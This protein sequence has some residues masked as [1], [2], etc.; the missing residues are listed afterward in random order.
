MSTVLVTGATGFIGSHVCHALVDDGWSVTAL[1]RRSSNP[2]RL[3]D[4]DV[5]WAVADVL[6]DAAVRDAI[7]GHTHVVHLAGV[8]LLD[9][10][11]E[12]VHRVNVVG[13]K[14]VLAACRSAEVERVVFTSTAGTR[15][16]NGGPATEDDVADPIGIY[17]RSKA[18]AE[19][20]VD[21]YAATVGDA[22]TVHP[23]SVFGPGDETFTARLLALATDPRMVA[24]LP[25]GASV[26]DVRNVAHGILNAMRV[27]ERGEHYILGGENLTYE[28]ILEILAHLSG[29]TAPR[30]RIPAAA[31]HAAGTPVEVLNT[32]F[33]T[34]LFP[35]NAEMARLATRELFYSST[36]AATHLGYDY[37][38]LRSHADAAIEWYLDPSAPS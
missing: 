32:V 28:R 25:G 26:V 14:H 22:V 7:D 6:D 18:E 31:I 15:R 11:Q 38:C 21:D 5:S 27:G 10:D 33:G 19:A 20:L 34:R 36:K 30:F 9:A 29:G 23:T 4:I 16:R 2:E 12:T 13:T 37:R 3:A 8:G 1:R 24:S 17:Q 35:V